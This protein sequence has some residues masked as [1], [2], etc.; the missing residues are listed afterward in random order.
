MDWQKNRLWVGLVALLVTGGAAFMAVKSGTGDSPATS[1][2][3]SMS[4]FPEEVARDTITTL[5][6]TQPDQPTL[7]LVRGEGGWTLAA[8]VEARADQTSVD[9]ALDK[10]A[11]LHLESIAARNASHHAELEVDAAQAIHVVARGGDDVLADLWVGGT[12]SGNTAVRIGD[13]DTVGMVNGAI[14]FAFVRELKDWRDRTITDVDAAEVREVAWRGPNGTF[15]FTRPMT[16]PAATEENA[17]PE[18][19]LG[20]WT[21]AEASYIPAAPAADPAADPAVTAPAAPAEPAVPVTTIENF[22]PTKVR[23]MV[24]T[25]ARLRAADFAAADVT[26]ATAGITDASPTVTL[27][28]GEGAT[29]TTTTL[30][31]GNANAEQFYATR[32]GDDTVFLVSSMHASRINPTVTEFQPSATPE[33][34]PAPEGGMPGGLP[35]DIQMGGPGG[36]E[37]PPEIMR[38][39]QQQLQQQGAHP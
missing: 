21:L 9:T 6:I 4:G 39:I 30:H 5:E 2:G 27:T 34:P 11:E 14:R 32:D 37:I 20:D 8:P 35:P 7:R 15:R 28:I 1:S 3:V 13:E 33:P 16:T 17:N 26:A 25:L 10:I 22:Q 12:R 18:P 31:L 29:A 24:S 23:T 36:G 38:Q 19:A